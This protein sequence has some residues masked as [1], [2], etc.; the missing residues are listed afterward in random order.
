MNQIL[1]PVSEQERMI[2]LDMMRGFA[3]LGIYLVNMLSFHSPYPYIDP[4]EWFSGPADYTTYTFIDIFIQASFYTL[5][6][7]LFGYS[8]VLFREKAM[9]KGLNFR[10]MAIR[11][12]TLLFLIGVVHAFLIWH[13]DILITYALLGFLFLLFIGMK[14]KTLMIT[15]FLL[16]TI[17]NILLSLLLLLAVSFSSGEELS[18]FDATAAETAKQVYQNGS[19]YE[20]TLQRM[21]DW[22]AV[23]NLVSLP[24]MLISIFPLFLIGG[25]AAKLKW[26]ENPQ[27]NRKM[28]RNVLIASLLFGLFIKL[29]PYMFTRNAATDYIQDIFGGP[30]LAIGYGIGIALLAEKSIATRILLS[31]SWVGRMSMSNYLFQSIL[32]TLIFYQYGLGFYGEIS[33]FA[34]TLL[35]VLIFI[36]QILFSRFWMMRFLYGPVEWLWRGFT[37]FRVPRLKRS[38]GN[39]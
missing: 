25:G 16:Y 30:L 33:V 7:L 11:R 34:G 29:I 26:F 24:I 32:S 9:I 39:E 38:S 2:S 20:I 14:G 21:N 15:G 5:F 4:K 12:L 17:P 37:Y 6:S 27:K 22:Y 18:V 10:R 8:L 36:F 13:G 35:V 3:I 23:N 31:L 19:F 28:L 1:N